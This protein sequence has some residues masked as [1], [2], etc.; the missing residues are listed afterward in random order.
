MRAR[1]WKVFFCLVPAIFVTALVGTLI[2]P[3]VGVMFGLVTFGF[4]WDVLS[5]D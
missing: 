2:L 1:M 3:V 4:G 5:K